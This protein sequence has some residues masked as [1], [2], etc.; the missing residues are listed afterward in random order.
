MQSW[1]HVG[2]EVYQVSVNLLGGGAP[3]LPAAIS[4]TNC[5]G[6]TLTPHHDIPYPTPPPYPH[7]IPSPP[8]PLSIPSPP[9]P[10]TIP[11]PPYPHTIPSPPHPHS[12]PS[13]PYPHTI[14]SPPHPHTIPSPPYLH[15]IPCLTQPPRPHT[16]HASPHCPHAHSSCP[17]ALTPGASFGL[18]RSVTCLSSSCTTNCRP[19]P[20]G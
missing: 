13:S 4:L 8:Y 6:L 10:H 1:C 15:T 11:S 17:R 14:P 9:Y 19:C 16:C 2:L 7:T 18:T 12:I 20:C 3:Q 5:R